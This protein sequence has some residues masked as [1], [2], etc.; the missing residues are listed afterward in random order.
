VLGCLVGKAESR[1][2]CWLVCP[3]ARRSPPGSPPPR[4][5]RPSSQAQ[6]AVD[7][8][9]SPKPKQPS[10]RAVAPAPDALVPGAGHHR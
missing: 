4:R 7:T 3:I 1:P 8:R 2:R 5:R 6:P 9:L 10:D